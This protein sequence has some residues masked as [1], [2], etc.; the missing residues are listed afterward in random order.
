MAKSTHC[1]HAAALGLEA[2]LLAEQGFTANPDIFDAPRGLA[3]AFFPDFVAEELL[4]FGPPFRVVEPGFAVKLFPSQYGTHF[5][6]TAGLAARA[7]VADV[8]DPGAIT[9]V[10]LHAP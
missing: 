4:R 7:E 1:G 3:D 8:A 6:I 2:A 9:A 10:R 5:G